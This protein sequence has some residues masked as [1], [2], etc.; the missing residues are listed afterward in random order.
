MTRQPRTGGLGLGCLPADSPSGPGSGGL[1]DERFFMYTEDVDLCARCRG[2]ADGTCS[3]RRRRRSSIF[4]VARRVGRSGRY[5]AA[6]RRSHM[7]FY[8]KHH[9]DWAP[10]LRAYLRVRGRMALIWSWRTHKIPCRLDSSAPF[11]N[12]AAMRFLVDPALARDGNGDRASMLIVALS[13]VGT[14]G[15]RGSGRRRRPSRYGRS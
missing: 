12:E 8:E 10:L 5:T 14:P 11:L 15:P 7:A 4:V 1:L 6:Y 9:P 13:I 3:S 2:P